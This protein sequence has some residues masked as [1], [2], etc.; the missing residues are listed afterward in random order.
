MQDVRPILF[1]DVDGVINTCGSALTEVEVRTT[2]EGYPA[3]VPVGAADRVSR[4]LE[5]FDP[6][7]LTTWEDRA[8]RCWAHLIGVDPEPEWPH[9]KWRRARLDDYWGGSKIEGMDAW[10]AERG[11]LDRPWVWIDDDGLYWVNE[12][13]KRTDYDGPPDHGMIVAPTT[14][15]GIT[16]DHVGVALQ[17]AETW[18]G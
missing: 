2:V 16:D 18:S 15:V 9:V 3:T 13:R 5:A 14:R 6:V 1:L 12:M 8:H 17:H 4:L 10:L 7:W 11:W